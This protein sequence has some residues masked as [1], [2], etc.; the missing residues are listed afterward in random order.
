MIPRR[1]VLKALAL[2]PGLGAL[3]VFGETAAPEHWRPLVSAAAYRVLF[4]EATE[5]PYSSPLNDQHA[6]GTFVCNGCDLPLFRSQWKF[7]SHTGWPSFYD[8]L[9]NAIGTREDRKLIFSVRTEV[10]CRRCGG[11]FG[12]VFDDGPK[13]TGKRHCLNGLAITFKPAV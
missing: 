12:H 9:P 13:P 5:R 4:E 6:R 10:H 3:R 1:T 11:H 8:A 7:D 2:L